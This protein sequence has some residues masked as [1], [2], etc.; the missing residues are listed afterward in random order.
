MK[1]WR[2]INKSHGISMVEGMIALVVL[3]VGLLALF[4]FQSSLLSSGADA[5]ARAEALQIAD[6]KLG[7]LRTQGS[8]AYGYLKDP[9]GTEVNDLLDD[10]NGIFSGNESVAGTNAA[11]SVS[12]SG[13]NLTGPDR[14]QVV[15]T[16]AWTDKDGSQQVQLTGDIRW[17]NPDL[18]A[19][20]LAKS[21]PGGGSIASPQGGA[22]YSD[23]TYGPN[24][25]PGGTPNV[26][27]D[28]S[29]DGTQM[30]YNSSKGRWELIDTATG[31]ILLTSSEEFLTVSGR[32]IVD[33]GM[34]VNMDWIRAGAPDI[35]YCTTTHN[36]PAGTPND[37]ITDGGTTIFKYVN[38]RCY[39][40]LGWFGSIAVLVPNFDSNSTP[41]PSTL[42]QHDNTCVGEPGVSDDGTADSRHP[43][44]SFVRKY[45]GYS[46]L[47]DESGAR[48][49]SNGQRLYESSGQSEGDS[50]TGQD[51]YL[52]TITLQS[53]PG[54]DPSIAAAN[55]AL[56]GGV[57]EMAQKADEFSNNTGVFVCLTASCP[58]V[59]PED[60]GTA[61][62]EVQSLYTWTIS[63]S[64]SGGTLASVITSDGDSCS[65]GDGTSSYTCTV[66]DLGTGWSGFIEATA[67]S[68]YVIT[69][70]RRRVFTDLTGDSSGNGFTLGS[71]ESVVQV[72]ITGSV[73]TGPGAD[74][75]GITTDNG[76]TCSA[77]LNNAG[78]VIDGPF[79]CVYNNLV[80]GSDVTLTFTTDD[81]VCSSSGTVSG[82]TLALSNVTGN[83][84]NVDALITRS[85]CP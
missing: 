41:L 27:E 46:P 43:Q 39:T 14:K 37:Q 25:I 20:L 28:G 4:S 76:G 75:D 26:N 32:I 54:N 58:A 77:S 2:I 10:E 63:G 38:Y 9:T 81:N 51:F 21:L 82:T 40:G 59:L 56:C 62:D 50:Y 18:G 29:N 67:A 65:I 22:N 68:G 85:T 69:D 30:Y 72:T 78:N 13:S 24:S 66:Y 42:G 79:E 84:T 57:D 12:W 34:N 53:N 47:V 7:E 55:D 49:D 71:S 19:A 52:N 17:N 60:T 1:A 23:E 33:A 74:Y 6:S 70:G 80:S 61:L 31:D 83:L 5:K 73:D 35:S 16:V 36:D 8:L 48:I 64:I 44:L 3:G 11:F 45:R 15:V